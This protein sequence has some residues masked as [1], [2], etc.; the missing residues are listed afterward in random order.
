M[1]MVLS[2][3][4]VLKKTRLFVWLLGRT[5]GLGRVVKLLG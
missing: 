1:N 2:S 4:N 3:G 5:K